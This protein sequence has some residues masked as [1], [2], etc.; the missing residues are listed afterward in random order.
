[1]EKYRLKKNFRGFKRGMQFFL[2]AHSEFIGVKEFVLRTE[3]LSIR[4][5]INE[6][7]LK[8]NFV[9]VK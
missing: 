3:D 9:L 5:A 8:K 4:I 7:E 1:M 6:A 2:V